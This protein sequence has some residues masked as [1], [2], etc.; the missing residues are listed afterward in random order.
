[1]PK[2]NMYRSL[3]TSVLGPRSKPLEVQIRTRQMHEVAEYGVAAHW[4]YKEAGCPAINNKEEDIKFSWMRKFIELDKEA[5][6]TNEFVDQV[7]SY[8]YENEVFVFT[9]MGDV[10][11]LPQGA[12][13]IDFA[14]R[15]HSDVGS[16]TVGALINGRIAQLDTPLVNG[17]IV[18]I[19]TDMTYADCIQLYYDKLNQ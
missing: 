5:N 9:P 18:E 12:T 10:F 6:N 8:F 1:M 2:A 17:D 19:L 4:K 14:F 15:I 11:D 13:A 3:H 16:K 7:K